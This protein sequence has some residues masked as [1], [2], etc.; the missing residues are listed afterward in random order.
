MEYWADA[1][2]EMRQME[3]NFVVRILWSPL[4]D[5]LPR[6]ETKPKQYTQSIIWCIASHL[7]LIALYCIVFQLICDAL[8]TSA[9]QY[10]T[11]CVALSV[12]IFV[13]CRV[14]GWV[15]DGLPRWVLAGGYTVRNIYIPPSP[16]IYLNIVSS[17]SPSICVRS[18]FQKKEEF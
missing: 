13:L 6:W 7:Q 17:S 1:S 4:T 16:N 5:R 18:L 9:F 11:P 3:Y 8:H 10:L 15:S 14:N 2:V 12:C